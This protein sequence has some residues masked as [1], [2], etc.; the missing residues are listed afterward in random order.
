MSGRDWVILG[1]GLAM[2]GV[3]VLLI[4]AYDRGRRRDTSVEGE[5]AWPDPTWPHGG[6]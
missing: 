5:E 6:F 4:V 2:V 1:F 3:K